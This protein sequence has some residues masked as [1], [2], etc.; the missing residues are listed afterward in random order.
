MTILLQRPPESETSLPLESQ[1]NNRRYFECD[2][3]TQSLSEKPIWGAFGSGNG[4]HL[5][6]KAI[7]AGG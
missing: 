4:P 1:L 5:A 7:P 3:I 2:F 6:L